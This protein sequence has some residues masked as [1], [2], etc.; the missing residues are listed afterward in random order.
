VT[1][2]AADAAYVERAARHELEQAEQARRSRRISL[3]RLAVFVA[4]VVA[5]FAGGWP[6]LDGGRPAL[7]LAAVLALAF[8]ALIALHER[9]ERRA[10]WA[11]LLARINR[12]GLARLHR[13]WTALPE[14]PPALVEPMHPYAHDLGVVGR[15]S[16]YHLLAGACGTHGRARLLGWLLA[17]ASPDLIPPRQAAVDELAGMPD[18]RDA[19]QAHA[20]LLGQV[21]PRQLERFLAWAEDEPWLTRAGWRVWII[22]LLPALTLTLAVLH[23]Q[24]ATSR[25]FWLLPIAA[26]WL[27]TARWGR[28][29][30]ETLDRALPDDRFLQ[31]YPALFRLLHD[32]PFTT[33]LLRELRGAL[34]ADGVPAAD[35]LERLRRVTDSGYVRYSTLGHFFAQSLLLWDFHV[36]AALE[37]WQQQSGRRLRTWLELLGDAEALGALAILRHDSPDWCTPE[38]SDGSDPVLAGARLAHPLIPPAA[39]VPNDAEVG[40]PGTI[41]LVTGS[42]MAG[43]STLLRAI[44]LNAVLAQ[45]GAPD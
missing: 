41:L 13:D 32:A 27:L 34:E 45:T 28:R 5:L 33:P 35:E 43:K 9:I 3:A 18:T 8:I 40:P 30:A 14:P 10:A 44:G 22:Y 42:N 6:G 36:V 24:G 15:A 1:P 7:V 2:S 26:G 38:I 20:R 16:L 39:A 12:E 11:G 21:P 23:G 25:P 17:P 4:L 19:L 37:R 29:A 31:R